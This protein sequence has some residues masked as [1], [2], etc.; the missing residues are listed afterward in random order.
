MIDNY[1]LH[2]CYRTI[3][4]VLL[5]E[6]KS[7]AHP[8]KNI[9]TN[10][11][12]AI[13]END[14]LVGINIFDFGKVVKIKNQGMIYLPSNSL[15]DVINSLLKNAGLDSLS[16]K[17]ESGYLIGEVSE[18]FEVSGG[19]LCVMKIN[20][21]TYSAFIKNK[22]ELKSGDKVVIAING[23]RL[24]NGDIVKERSGE[25]GFTDSHLCSLKDLGLEDNETILIVDEDEIVGK[26]FF[27]M[28]ENK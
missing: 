16:Y 14:E 3:G 5:I 28:E 12:V 21:D 20:H 4:D 7:S 8:T 19:F 1:S 27:S 13:Y 25:F 15:I 18:I 6:L 10:N 2:Y 24:S 23:N 26:D 9:K 11:V 22:D 17:N